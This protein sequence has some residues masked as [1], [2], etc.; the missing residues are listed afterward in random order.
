MRIC[1]LDGNSITDKKTLHDILA[2]ALQL[3]DWYGRNLD[4]LYDCLTDMKEEVEILILN[5][6]NL[7]AH[8][9]AYARSLANVIG[10]ASLENPR[11]NITGSLPPHG[12]CLP[13]APQGPGDIFRL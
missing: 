6:E 8:L 2:A 1:T 5:A 11:I 4:A 10:K 9:G 13:S 12:P 7:E 3:P